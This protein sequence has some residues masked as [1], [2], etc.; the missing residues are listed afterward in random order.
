MN[1]NV[2]YNG[3]LFPETTLVFVHFGLKCYIAFG[4]KK[5]SKQPTL[6]RL[7]AG[8]FKKY[9]VLSLNLKRYFTYDCFF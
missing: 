6:L 1:Q 7:A 8:L 4:I 5:L 3:K 9:F 2:T